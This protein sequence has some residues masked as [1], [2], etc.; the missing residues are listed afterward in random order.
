[1]LGNKI[2]VMSQHEHLQA[3]MSD[4]AADNTSTQP[5]HNQSHQHISVAKLWL[6]TLLAVPAVLFS[7]TLQSIFGLS[8][9]FSGSE[10]ISPVAAIIL[11]FTVGQTFL[12]GGFVELRHGKPGMMALIALA[13][14]VAFGYSIFIS[15]GQWLG[16]E[17]Q[18]MDFWWELATLIAIMAW[19]HFIEARSVAAANKSLSSLAEMLP[20]EVEIFRD[21]EVVKISRAEVLVGDLVLVRPGS[22]VPVDGLVVEGNSSVDEALITGESNPVSKPEGSF[23]VAGSINSVNHT[24]GQGSLT[25]RVLR[26]GESTSL[27]AIMQLVEKAKAAKSKTQVLADRA[28]GWLFYIALLSALATLAGWLIAGNQSLDFILE[29]VVTVLVIACP[30]AL[31]LAIPLVSAISVSK[32]AKS[33]LLIRNRSAFE[34]AAKADVVIFDKTGTLT[35][36]KRAFVGAR[37][38]YGS[39]LMSTDELIALAASVELTAEHSI[40]KCIVDQAHKLK[41]TIPKSTDFRAIP[42]QGVTAVLGGQTISVGGPVLLT[43]RNIPIYVD[44]VVRADAAHQAGLSVVFVV[45]NGELLGSIE[46]GDTLRET[47]KAAVYELQLRRKRVVM[48]TG[49]ATG[50]AESVAKELGITEV[51]AEV[52]PH[53][54]AE[55]VR[56]LQVDGSK[57]IMVGDGINDAPALAQANVGVA[58]GAGTNV[59]IESAGIVLSSDDPVKILDL[60]QQ[61]R[62]SVAKMKQNLFWAVGYNALAIPLAG[63]ALVGAGLTLTPALG[64]LLM[65]ISTLVVAANAQLLRRR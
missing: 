28:A 10:L 53:R 60:I 15:T 55:V 1:M 54:K 50:V 17:F 47:A 11:F 7:P 27:A 51:F 8:W 13:L 26:T 49:D 5:S 44:D 43:A 3:P 34:Q 61:S 16:F 4:P 52:L 6:A 30:H 25:V 33:G 24:L 57:V 31:G 2:S 14:V 58:I 19:G 21:G 20:N 42:G 38:A 23:V 22:V 12:R 46:V 41:V 62:E 29:R 35:T 36:A 56:K 18:G 9:V 59:A 64:A 48:L 32:A 65:S 40:A 37:L 39:E 63:G 45:R